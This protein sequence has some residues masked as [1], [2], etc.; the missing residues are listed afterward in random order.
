MKFKELIERDPSLKKYIVKDRNGEISHCVSPSL[1]KSQGI[2]DESIAKLVVLHRKRLDLFELMK[3]LDLETDKEFLYE[4][5]KQWSKNEFLMQG[6][7][8][9]KKDS[10]R[11]AFW[12]MPHCTCAKMDNDEAYPYGRYYISGDCYHA[13]TGSK[14]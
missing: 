1:A 8:G 6:L 12:H 7:W 11:H 10:D 5:S 9:F 4:C 2:D 3:T 13:L 14:K